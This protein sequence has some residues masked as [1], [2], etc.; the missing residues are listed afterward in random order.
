[1]EY[2]AG[3]RRLVPC[4]LS[5]LIVRA[6]RCK[7]NI[8]SN[9]NPATDSSRPVV[10]KRI[11]T[12]MKVEFR[13]V[14][15]VHIFLFFLLCG[16]NVLRGLYSGVFITWVRRRLRLYLFVCVFVCFFN[17]LICL[18]AQLLC[19][20][21]VRSDVV[22]HVQGQSQGSRSRAVMRAPSCSKRSIFPGLYPQ[23]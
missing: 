1:M 18:G 20:L 11:Y 19:V 7:P 17:Q 23:I 8:I 10:F 12:V 16:V 3:S 4:R 21:D 15:F 13:S 2:L 5:S 6:P 14:S 9:Y 22:G